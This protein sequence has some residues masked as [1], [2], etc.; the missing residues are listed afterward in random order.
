LD[1]RHAQIPA[2]V[3]TTRQAIALLAMYHCR[4]LRPYV[5]LAGA[6]Y[7]RKCSQ[8]DRHSVL[9]RIVWSSAGRCSPAHKAFKAMQAMFVSLKQLVLLLGLTLSSHTGAGAQST[10]HRDTFIQSPSS[11]M[12]VSPPR[13]APP[14]GSSVLLIQQLGDFHVGY[15]F[16]VTESYEHQ[17]PMSLFP[18]QQTKTSFVTESR[19]LVTQLW[20]ARLQVNLFV[21][22]FHSGNF[23]LGPS[24]SNEAFHR[25]RQVGEPPSFGLYGIGISVPLGRNARR[26]GSTGLWRSF[27]RIVHGGSGGIELANVR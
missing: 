27:Q 10:E 14:L 25:P 19:L 3:P 11:Q 24:V 12:I 9:L 8:R 21:V 4:F 17:N 20:G 23:M 13:Q 26:E 7:G 15:G 18:F 22:T 5:S 6:G 1:S 2:T 16:R